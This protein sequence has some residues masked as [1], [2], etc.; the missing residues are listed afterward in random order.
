MIASKGAL[1]SYATKTE[2]LGKEV[3]ERLALEAS[4]DNPWSGRKFK[5]FILDNL[6]REAISHDDDLFVVPQEFCPK[7]SQ[8]EQALG[9]IYQSRGGATHGGHPYP[10]SAFVGPSTSIPTKAFDAI[11]NHQRPFPPI[12]W[13]ERVLNSA[14]CGFIRS[15]VKQE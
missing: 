1:V 14:I 3:V 7:E 11:I 2:K 15:Q 13:F 9:E 6:D 5:K 12:G 10:A 8:I 4:K